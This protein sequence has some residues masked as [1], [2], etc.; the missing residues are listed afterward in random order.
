MNFEH[1]KKQCLEKCDYSK[2]QSIDKEIKPLVDLINSFDNYYTTSSCSGRIL[3]IENA[4][5]HNKQAVEWAFVSHEEV[6]FDDVKKSV[7]PG[8]DLW[9]K[10]EGAILHIC[11]RTMDDAQKLLR[12]AQEEGFKR[13][14]IISFHKRIIVEIIS[15]DMMSTVISKNKKM[16]VHE[17]YLKE[18]ADT[19]NEKMSYNLEKLKRLYSALKKLS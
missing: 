17:D 6:G 10:F 12:L 1:E 19:A 18:L 7:F 8:D 16:L 5:S 14:G 2:K 4:E 15:T 9:F 13:A 3:L 11:C